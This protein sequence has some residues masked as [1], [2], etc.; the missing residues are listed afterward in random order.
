M[1]ARFI[2]QLFHCFV[3]FIPETLFFSALLNFHVISLG[4]GIKGGA[5][6]I[7]GGKNAGHGEFPWM[8]RTS[9]DLA[10]E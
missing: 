3:V 8:V 10:C 5:S 1:K 4:C 6:N 7:I 2:D 9:L